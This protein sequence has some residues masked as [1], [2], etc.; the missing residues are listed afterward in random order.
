MMLCLVVVAGASLG[1]SE[2]GW[3]SGTGGR[4]YWKAGGAGG[5]DTR[6]GDDTVGENISSPGL[7]GSNRLLLLVLRGSCASSAGALFSA[8]RYDVELRLRPE[9]ETARLLRSSVMSATGSFGA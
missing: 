7:S 6:S 4:V 3:S 1:S 5:R 8:P 2:T 9:S